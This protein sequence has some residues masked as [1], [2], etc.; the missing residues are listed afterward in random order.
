MQIYGPSHLHG[1]HPIN[2]P[3]GQRPAQP[4]E[5]S[6][7]T[8]IAD[9]VEISPAA[10]QAEASQSAGE[11]REDRVQSIRAQIARGTYETPEKLEVAVARLLDEIG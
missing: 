6:G 2:A 11:V 8:P 3:H 7:A 5:R 9:E 4:A 10:R 1:P